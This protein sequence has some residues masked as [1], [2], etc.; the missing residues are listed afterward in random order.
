MGNKLSEETYIK[1]TK[2]NY[3]ARCGREIT[4]KAIYCNECHRKEMIRPIETLPVTR[5]ELKRKIRE[6]PF[7]LIG[8]EYGV[9]DNAI[10]K[11]CKKLELPYKSSIIKLYSDEEWENI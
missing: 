2:H 4:L 11:W 3:C 5:D 9:T 7:V 10:R 8:K 1:K 6:I